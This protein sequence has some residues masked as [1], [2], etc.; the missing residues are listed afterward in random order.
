MNKTY[1]FTDLHGHYN[2]WKQIKDYADSTDKLFFLGDAIDRGPDGIKIMQELLKDERVIYLKGNHEDF[3]TRYT[4]PGA[5]SLWTSLNNG[6][7]PTYKEM[8]Q[9]SQ[10][11]RNILIQQ[12]KK[13]PRHFTYVNKKGQSIFL[14]HA[15]ATPDAYQCYKYCLDD[16]IWD[17][18][19]FCEPW[20][21][22][23]EFKE[24][25]VVH[26]HT[27]TPYVNYYIGNPI[28]LNEDLKKEDIKVLR[29]AKGHKICLDLATD[30]T[31]KA[32][33]Y[34]L[35]EMKVE[36]YFYDQETTDN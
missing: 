22:E 29:Y 19:H 17:R 28:S 16:L 23:E 15:G 18:S 2:L 1:C 36:R 14:S 25:Y 8:L 27:P 13:L 35:D 4:S 10:E 33:L 21:P 26:G 9:L 3:L 20:P 5:L 30:Y 12:I 34:D 7:Q 6:G 31:K 11:E 32:V 24:T